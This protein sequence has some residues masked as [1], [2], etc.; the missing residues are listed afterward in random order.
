MNYQPYSKVEQ[1]DYH[2]TLAMLSDERSRRQKLGKLK[3]YQE[4]RLVSM[5]DK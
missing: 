2:D 5:F 4:G 3:E 1:K